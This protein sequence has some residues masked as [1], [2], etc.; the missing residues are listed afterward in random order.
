MHMSIGA[1]TFDILGCGFSIGTGF[2]V[3]KNLILTAAHNIYHK[4]YS[5]PRK[6]TH[7]KFFLAANG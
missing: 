2:L 1:I 7:M 3:S 4:N 5:P 6:S